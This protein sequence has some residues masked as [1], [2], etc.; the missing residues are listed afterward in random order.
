M[1][2]LYALLV[3]C[4]QVGAGCMQPNSAEAVGKQGTPA[5]PVSVDSLPSTG[6]PVGLAI[7]ENVDERFDTFLSYFNK[8]SLFQVSRIVFPLRYK[9]VDWD[10]EGL[11]LVERRVEPAT[12]R[13][14]DFSYDPA[15]ANR[16]LDAYEQTIKV[17]GSKAIIEIRGIENGISTDCYFEKRKGKW[18]LYFIEDSST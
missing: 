11:D 7:P 14:M 8:D 9:E 1:K 13:M 15:V 10:T 5:E 16:E 4:L 6:Q 12:F 18:M 2:Y 17:K 3:A